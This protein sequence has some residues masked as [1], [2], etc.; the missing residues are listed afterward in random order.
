MVDSELLY[1]FPA[2]IRGRN[3]VF[4]NEEFEVLVK[5][6]KCD[7]SQVHVTLHTAEHHPLSPLDH[8]LFQMTSETCGDDLK[9]TFIFS[10]STYYVLTTGMYIHVETMNGDSMST[11]IFDVQE[12]MVVGPILFLVDKNRESQSEF[13]FLHEMNR[14]SH[15]NFQHLRK[16]YAQTVDL[17]QLMLAEYRDYKLSTGM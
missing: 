16:A 9:V 10:M 3:I 14:F 5:N 8:C 4:P 1:T 11:C 2:Q 13:S 15:E 7:K 12:M 6:V 17:L